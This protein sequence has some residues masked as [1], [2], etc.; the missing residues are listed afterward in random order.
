MIASLTTPDAG[1]NYYFLACVYAF[2]SAICALLFSLSYFKVVEGAEGWWIIPA[3]SII[4]LIYAVF[5]HAQSK[6]LVAKADTGK[7]SN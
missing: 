6:S 4:A 5:M 1:T 2:F 7:K 3:P